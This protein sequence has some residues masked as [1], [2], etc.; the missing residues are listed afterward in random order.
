MNNEKRLYIVTVS[1]EFQYPVLA[2]SE[3]AGRSEST[4]RA[5]LEDLSVIPWKSTVARAWPEYKAPEGYEQRSLVYHATPPRGDVTWAEAVK[6][7]RLYSERDLCFAGHHT[8]GLFGT[9]IGVTACKGVTLTGVDAQTSAVPA[10]DFEGVELG[11]ATT[12]DAAK[13]AT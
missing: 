13:G 11:S 1:L 10:G 9:A 7:D 5:A 4:V 8:V 6:A 12:T 2:D 3:A